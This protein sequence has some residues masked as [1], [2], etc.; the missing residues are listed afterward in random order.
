[1]KRI[2]E[3]LIA[4][5]LV[6]CLAVPAAAADSAFA[7]KGHSLFSFGPGSDFSDTDLFH[8]FKSV[9]PGDSLTQ[10]IAVKNEADCCDFVK[11]YIRAAVH[12]A[13]NPVGTQVTEHED[14]V[15][16]QDFLSQLTIT[17]QNGGQTVFAGKLDSAQNSVLLGSFRKN[18]GTELTAVLE[19]PANLGNEYAKRVGE[20]DW[21]FTVEEYND[22]APDTP[23][24]GDHFQLQRYGILMA[25]SL[26][27]IVAL[28]FAMRRKRTQKEYE[29][30]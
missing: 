20:V 11:I 22:T 10:K 4:A 15:S 30:V 27:G 28:L 17:V 25:A 23:Q 21:V 26:T 9:M 6:F 13:Q 3:L 2:T 16:M 18:E 19:V 7:Y 14:A 12:N 5:V 1:M 8:N 29:S 24:T